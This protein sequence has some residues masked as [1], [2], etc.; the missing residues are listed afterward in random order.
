MVKKACFTPARPGRAK[1]RPFPR[2]GRSERG[3]EAYFFRYVEVPSEARTQ[4]AVF[5]NILLIYA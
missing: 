5:F 2:Q 4:P 3:T 1:T